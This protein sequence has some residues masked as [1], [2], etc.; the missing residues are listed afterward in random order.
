MSCHADNPGLKDRYFIPW[1]PIAAASVST[2]AIP[3]I[4][5]TLLQKHYVKGIIGGVIKG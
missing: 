1:N 3:V 2:M 5:Y 4:L